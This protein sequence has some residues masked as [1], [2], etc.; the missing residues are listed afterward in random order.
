MQLEAGQTA[1]VTGA[2][3]GIG[4]GLAQAFAERGLNVVMADVEGAALEAAAPGVRALGG[5]VLT[6]S[7]DVR[8]EQQVL[9]L[10]QRTID[11]FGAVHVVCNN[12]G[13]TGAGDPWSGPIANWHWVVD[14]N[15]F[16]VV[17]GV[18][19]FLPHLVANGGH[20]V[21]T[22]SMAGLLPGI[23]AGYDATKHAVVALTE[24][25]HR[26]TKLFNLPVGVSCLCPGWV[27]TNIG[28]SERNFPAEYGEFQP[29][30]GFEEGRE[31][32]RQVLANGMDP[33]ALAELVV[34]AIGEGR[35]WVFSDHDAIPFA[36]RRWES[37]TAGHNPA[38]PEHLGQVIPTALNDA[39]D[40]LRPAP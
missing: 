17:H 39:L 35:Y 14:V 10:A 16:G 27:N 15:L 28:T 8:D 1:V 11:T 37:I 26:H 7:C 38:I 23:S 20:I 31:L 9:D 21:N 4:L 24:D 2:A 3:S 5:E 18:R 22:A 25:L 33:R 40:Q 13:V 12:A 32:V 30:A 34:A 6:V 29:I 36:T 19:A